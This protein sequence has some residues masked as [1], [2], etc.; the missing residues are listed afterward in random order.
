MEACGGSQHWTRRL[1]EMGHQVRLMAAKFVEAFNIANKNDQADARAI[2]MAT[3]MPSE[4]VAMK[5]K[6]S[7]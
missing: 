4:A 2:W 7:R 6:A 5:T 3:Q 1:M